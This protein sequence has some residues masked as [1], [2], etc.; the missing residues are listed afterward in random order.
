MPRVKM[1]FLERDNKLKIHSNDSES[2]KQDKASFNNT[3]EYIRVQALHNAEVDYR[4]NA[5]QFEYGLAKKAETNRLINDQADAMLQKLRMFADAWAES[6]NQMVDKVYEKSFG[7]SGNLYYGAIK[8][9][10]KNIKKI[11]NEAE[12]MPLRLKYGILYKCILNGT[13][14]KW[15]KTLALQ[16]LDSDKEVNIRTNGLLESSKNFDTILERKDENYAKSLGF[17]EEV[18]GEYEA[19]QQFSS[20]VQAV[21][22]EYM[23][24][25]EDGVSAYEFDRVGTLDSQKQSQKGHFVRDREYSN[26]T[27]NTRMKSSSEN[28]FDNDKLRHLKQD[29]LSTKLTGMEKEA[30]GSKGISFWG[31][32][33]GW[34]QGAEDVSLVNGTQITKRM[35]EFKARVVAGTSGSTDLMMHAFE[36]FGIRDIEQ[37]KIL[38]MG[39]LGWMVG[40]RDHSF[41]EI[42]TAAKGYGLPFH[43]NGEFIGSEYEDDDNLKPIGKGEAKAI[44]GEF[45]SYYYSAKYLLEKSRSKGSDITIPKKSFWSWGG[46]ELTE[47]EQMEKYIDSVYKSL[48]FTEEE[49]ISD[50]IP[51]NC[52]PYVVGL[53]KA[54][55]ELVQEYKISGIEEKSYPLY[56]MRLNR[57]V[58]LDMNYIYLSNTLNYSMFCKKIYRKIIKNLK[59]DKEFKNCLYKNIQRDITKNIVKVKGENY[60]KQVRTLE[61]EIEEGQYEQPENIVDLPGS[62]VKNVTQVRIK[63]A[64][65]DKYYLDNPEELNGDA[66]TKTRN[67]K[68]FNDLAKTIEKYIKTT[69]EQEKEELK[70]YLKQMDDDL[71]L[72]TLKLAESITFYNNN[73]NNSEKRALNYYSR[74]GY[75]TMNTASALEGR[76]LHTEEKEAANIDV[77][78]LLVDKKATVFLKSALEKMPKYE[79]T[80]YRVDSGIK[81]YPTNEKGE[82]EKGYNKNKNLKKLRQR[83]DKIETRSKFISTAY[84]ADSQY[85]NEHWD[86]FGVFN[87]ITNTKSG[88]NISLMAELQKEREV[89]FNPGTRFQITG[90]AEPKKYKHLLG[91]KNLKGHIVLEQKEV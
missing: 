59:V 36:Y 67:E 5:E 48:K 30:L 79:G 31:V 28:Y 57:E 73:C 50:A 63:N 12:T 61:K 29:D 51:L 46:G 91:G 42:F 1:D 16:I 7:G 80:V 43:H 11:F 45:P 17:I 18:N 87:V 25:G 78:K 47:N 56:S 77:E 84:Q 69:D 44:L 89:L 82:F 34:T 19:S 21:R 27:K 8:A 83:V 13:F 72:D 52:M 20:I 71:Q 4:K 23:Q 40:G 39:L 24:E 66:N 60:Q 3:P 2:V 90:I 22:D 68:A 26:L 32:I 64:L 6:T 70:A 53:T 10:A 35:N 76:L 55:E 88:V 85:I 75:K 14:T 54:I 86:E 33:K 81:N 62:E 37:K 15:M 41:H 74:L 49:K 58:K 9:T 38:R 65:L